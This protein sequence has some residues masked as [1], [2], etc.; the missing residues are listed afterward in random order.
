M[1]DAFKSLFVVFRST[2]SPSISDTICKK[3]SPNIFFA[4]LT[5]RLTVHE[6]ILNL[7]S[8]KSI[9]EFVQIK[10]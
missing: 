6:I 3:E 5:S 1:S 9:F 4:M 8:K 7:F 2:L 10:V